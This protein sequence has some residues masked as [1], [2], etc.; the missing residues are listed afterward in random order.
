MQQQ[1]GIPQIV[2]AQDGLFVNLAAWQPGA[3]TEWYLQDMALMWHEQQMA[4]TWEQQQQQQQPMGV[5]PDPDS[6][7]P[8]CAP[9]T[10]SPP[11]S[12]TG[13]SHDPMQGY[14][15]SQQQ[16]GSSKAGGKKGRGPRS[17]PSSGPSKIFTPP[18]PPPARPIDLSEE[19]FPAL[20][21]C[22]AAKTPV[23]PPKWGRVPTGKPLRPTAAEWSPGVTP[24]STTGSSGSEGAAAP[25]VTSP[26]HP[27]T[28]QLR[29][30]AP[31]WGSS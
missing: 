30:D 16:F 3:S 24:I 12:S 5:Y 7:S 8:L 10:I 22:S 17:R 23:Q 18:P 1:A 6:G 9:S 21:G 31:A 28:P 20:G 15:A 4:Y 19:A 2:Q 14:A 29:P 26:V 25:A 13:D 27:T 11:G